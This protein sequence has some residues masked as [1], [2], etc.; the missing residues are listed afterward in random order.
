VLIK[1]IRFIKVLIVNNL[2]RLFDMLLLNCLQVYT[3]Y[4]N[5]FLVGGLYTCKLCQIE[6][7]H[8]FDLS[9]RT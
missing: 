1:K 6:G 5:M 4:K 2:V 3:T 7:K 9:N 8:P